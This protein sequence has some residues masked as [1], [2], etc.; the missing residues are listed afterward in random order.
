MKRV[1]RAVLA[2]WMLFVLTAGAPSRA[3]SD[4]PILSLD[5]EEPGAAISPTLFGLMFEE[6]NHSG[7]GGIY[8]ELIAN[9]AMLDNA[10]GA[11][12][13]G[14][15][16][17]D[18]WTLETTGQAAGSLDLD[19]QDPVNTTALPESLHLTISRVASGERVGI[20]NPGYSGIPARPSTTY[21]V[22][23]YA[24]SGAGFQ[25]PL[26][27]SLEDTAG[28]VLASG[29]VPTVS[30][31]WR[32]YALTLTTPA[33]IP[34]SEDN[35]FVISGMLVNYI[36]GRDL[37]LMQI[38]LGTSLFFY[39]RM[40]RLSL[41]VRADV[42]LGASPAHRLARRWFGG[43][44]LGWA[45]ILVLFELALLSKAQAV[46]LP[47]LILAFEL[48][49]GKGA[50]SRIAPYARALP[51]ALVA[52]GHLIFIDSYLGFAALPDAPNIGQDA[53]WT[54]PLTQAKL[55]LF[56][57]LANFAWPFDLRQMPVEPTMNSLQDP[58]VA[59]GLAF[60]VATL[61]V[62]WLLRR[63]NPLLAFCLLAYWIAQSPESSVTP[64]LH[65]AAD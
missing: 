51:F 38:F 26:A 36:S 43:S 64:M 56:H 60:I 63:A 27:I 16:N 48:T 55:S 31:T 2:V 42:L 47:A 5:V 21:R 40:R 10:P 13:D 53:L 54:Y 30:V 23:F 37:L 3:G 20:V 32:R 14:T 29:S 9:R 41:S 35:H 6:I 34:P 12:L 39:I 19:A 24:R 44:T 33:T 58:G 1:P 46:M 52:V 17:Y 61:A 4:P 8:G 25:G 18:P 15:P 45:G 59:I 11:S 65:N 62:A 22:S 50:L 7:D 57:Y 49:L 28:K